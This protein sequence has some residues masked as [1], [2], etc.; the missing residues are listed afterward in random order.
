MSNKKN[1][2]KKAGFVLAIV[3]MLTP[4]LAAAPGNAG[5]YVGTGIGGAI[6]RHEGDLAELI[7][8]ENGLGWELLHLGYNFTDNFGMGLQWGAAAG[9]AESDILWGQGYLVL[10]GRF[11]H[12]VNE[13]FVPYLEIG[14][15]P[16]LF[17]Y[18]E[19]NPED[20]IVSDPVLGFRFALGASFYFGRFYIGPELS[21]HVARYSDWS[22]RPEEGGSFDFESDETG[23]MLLILLKFGF[24]SRR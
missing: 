1:W 10:S 24:H 21:Y 2:V 16:Y 15:G 20:E 11:S 12:V 17:M 22:Y 13:R 3:L 6:P 23:D 19:E 9:P 7:E 4:A 5:F 14:L 8:A 18:L